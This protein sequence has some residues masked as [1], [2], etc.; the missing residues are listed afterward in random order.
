M[1]PYPSHRCHITLT[2]FPPSACHISAFIPSD[3][4]ALRFFITFT[5]SL[6][7]LIIIRGFF[8][9]SSLLLRLLLFLDSESASWYSCLQ[10]FLQLPRM[11]GQFYSIVLPSSLISSVLGLKYIVV[12]RI[13]LKTTLASQERNLNLQKKTSKNKLRDVLKWIKNAEKCAV[14]NLNTFVLGLFRIFQ[15]WNFDLFQYFYQSSKLIIVLEGGREDEKTT[16]WK[17]IQKIQFG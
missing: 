3:P 8:H 4:K 2:A 5:F 13:F 17:S 6:T 14:Q 12:C 15:W 1:P 9:W 7:S 16:Y 11:S 10:Y